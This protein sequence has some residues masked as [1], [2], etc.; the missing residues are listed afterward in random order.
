MGTLRT[1]SLPTKMHTHFWT[2]EPA[3]DIDPVM[4]KRRPCLAHQFVL[5]H[6]PTGQVVGIVRKLPRERWRDGCRGPYRTAW[7]SCGQ[8][9]T[10]RHE[11]CTS[12]RNFLARQFTRTRDRIR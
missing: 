7:F 4:A 1:A 5:R 3:T 8:I 2:T 10:K 11:S 12:A 9:Q 6:R